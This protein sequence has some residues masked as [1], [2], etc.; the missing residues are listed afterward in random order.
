MVSASGGVT[1]N[2]TFGTFTGGDF[3]LDNA[4]SG[5][6]TWNPDA[7]FADGSDTVLLQNED[8]SPNI[9]IDGS[10]TWGV[11]FGNGARL[12]APTGLGFQSVNLHN[13][14]TTGDIIENGDG[15]GFSRPFTDS[16]VFSV[17][18]NELEEVINDDGESTFVIVNSTDPFN[19][20]EAGVPIQ[21]WLEFD[22]AG[23]SVAGANLIGFE[24]FSTDSGDFGPNTPTYVAIDNLELAAVAVPE[25]SSLAILSLGALTTLLRRRK[26]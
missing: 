9:G 7:V 11:V 22:L 16:D 8:G 3:W 13:T 14:Q 19:L 5:Q 26:S 24:F 15:F 17:R 2:N 25:P 12:T 10:D 20:T 23:T 1:F 6:T 18:I 4:Y 21:G